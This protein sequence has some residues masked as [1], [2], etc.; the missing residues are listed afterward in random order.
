MESWKPQFPGRGIL[1]RRFYEKG[2]ILRSVIRQTIEV[3]ARFAYDG[4]DS[5]RRKT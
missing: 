2:G 4:V 3:C 1:F 5:K